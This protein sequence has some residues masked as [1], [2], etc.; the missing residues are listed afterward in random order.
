M[1]HWLT[2]IFSFVVDNVLY[3][4]Y[5]ETVQIQDARNSDQVRDSCDS[6]TT[7]PDVCNIIT[8][9]YGTIVGSTLS[10]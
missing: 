10:Q 7:Q 2:V 3:S 5:S 1:P 4:N 8:F 6:S 9:G